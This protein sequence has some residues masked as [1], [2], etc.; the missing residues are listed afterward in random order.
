[1]WG[2][3]PDVLDTACTNYRDHIAIVDADRRIT[4]LELREWR[5]RMANALVSSGMVKG[6]RVGLLLPNQLEFIPT[7]HGV[8]AAGGV[9]VQMPTRQTAEQFAST[10]TQTAATTLI[11]HAQF[12]AAVDKIRDRLPLLTRLV[13]VSG[14]DGETLPTGVISYESF[15]GGQ[16]TSRPN[17]DI[18]EHDEAYILFTSGST[19][20]PKGVI[21]SHFTWALRWTR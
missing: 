1:M 19:G 11:F 13:R 7:Q 21:N 2:T 14:G 10:L 6:E 16:P 5:N 20:E 12:D 9:L 18:D 15:I 17:I 8:W 3:L 4:Y